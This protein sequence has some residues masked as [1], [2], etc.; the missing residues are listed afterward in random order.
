[1]DTI[2]RVKLLRFDNSRNNQLT[3]NSQSEQKEFF[4]NRYGKTYSNCSYQDRSGIMTV[5][6]YVEDMRSF[7]YG[8]Y[9]NEYEGFYIRYYFWVLKYDYINRNTT[10]LTIALDLFQTWY[11]YISFKKC[12]IERAIVNDNYRDLYTYP[13]NFELGDY[14]TIKTTT[15]TELNNTIDFILAYADSD[16]VRGTYIGEYYSGLRFLYFKNKSSLDEKINEFCTNGKADAISYIFA[17]PRI[18]T[19]F[20]T[21]T[22]DDGEE[23]T[24]SYLHTY[25]NIEFENKQ[26]ENY[27]PRNRKLLNYPFH[28]ISIETS[29]GKN[30]ILKTELFNNTLHNFSLETV[31]SQCPIFSLVPYGYA[32]DDKSYSNSIET[33][34]F[35]LCSWNNDNYANWYA[36][37]KNTINN[38][39]NVADNV[40]R[41]NNKVANNNY[42]T[43]QQLAKNQLYSNV[44]NTGLNSL[45][46]LLS[47]NIGGA[48]G[49]A[50]GG[51]VNSY[52]GYENANLSNNNSL[53]NAKLMTNTN[54]DNTIS[55][56]LAQLEDSS[57]IPNTVKG[58]TSTNGLDICRGSG[59]FIIKEKALKREYAE[60]IDNYFSMYGYTIN[61]LDFPENYF[62]SRT[63]WNYIKTINAII[64]G[65]CPKEDL[66]ELENIFN[67]GVTLWHNYE[68]MYDYSKDNTII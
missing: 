13:E 56:L 49:N 53:E 9:E 10:K 42:A 62:N 40:K 7:N 18:F 28:F 51:G 3:F 48:L 29:E 67:E 59:T 23:I 44:T 1:M 30:I 35:G 19:F 57:V 37:H 33:Q 26:G 14:I 45:G 31:I 16:N 63:N 17:F 50:I 52:Y 65:T 64:L 4:D 34:P 22:P 46:N 68:T 25:L 12:F 60:R 20:E 43:N 8:Y 24:G 11:F 61:K 27:I 54:Y 55:T 15:L 38:N 6:A 36:Q 58:D 2:T 47:G 39:F 5:H 41:A 32:G 21:D 66:I